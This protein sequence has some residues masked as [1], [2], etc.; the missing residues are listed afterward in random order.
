MRSDLFARARLSA[1]RAVHLE[2]SCGVRLGFRLDRSRLEVDEIEEYLD[3]GPELTTE[4]VL[5]I[6]Q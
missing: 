2:S 5:G 1:V 3:L 6:C 4:A